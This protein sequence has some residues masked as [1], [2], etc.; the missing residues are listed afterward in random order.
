[1]ALGLSRAALPHTKE[2]RSVASPRCGG[3]SDL[4]MAHFVREIAGF[5]AHAEDYYASGYRD[6]DAFEA[7]LQSVALTRFEDE[8]ADE[9]PLTQKE[10][11]RGKRGLMR[12]IF[13]KIGGAPLDY[14]EFGV[15]DCKTFNR[16]VE[17]TP[18]GAARFYGFDTFEG[19]PEPWVMER[20]EAVGVGRAAGELKAVNAPAVFDARA[21][22]FKGLFQ[23][24][25][26]D[27]LTLAFPEGRKDARPLFL[28]IDSDL[29]TSALYALTSMHWLLRGGDHVYFDELFDSMNEFAAFNDYVRAYNTKAWFVP[30]AR[31]YDGLLFRI[32]PPPADAEGRAIIEKRTTGFLARAKAYARTRASLLKPANRG[33][34]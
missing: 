16:V 18:N 28:N 25:L 30:V 23:E 1:M 19:L 15:M 13:E 3:G 20:S 10:R 9:E 7:A 17:L 34:D 2:N 11:R 26:P 32:E 33:R 27:A 21:T 5:E 8:G 14:F 24:T 22:L 6:L 31:A 29:Y 12:W 4:E